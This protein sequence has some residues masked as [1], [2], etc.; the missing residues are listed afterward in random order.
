MSNSLLKQL[1]QFEGFCCE[2]KFFAYHKNSNAKEL[3]NY[4]GVDVRTI[5]RNRARIRSGIL[6]CNHTCLHPRKIYTIYC[7]R[8]QRE[9]RN[10]SRTEIE[11]KAKALW[12]QEVLKIFKQLG[13]KVDDVY[14]ERLF[15]VLVMR[16]RVGG[17]DGA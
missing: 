8:I 7:N 12:K 9:N 6:R 14:L 2:D 4:L 5:R 15:R 10:L 3:A 17:V 11:R 16:A 13:D 1:A